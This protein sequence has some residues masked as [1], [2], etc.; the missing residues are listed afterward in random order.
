MP[1]SALSMS[2]FQLMSI[3]KVGVQANAGVAHVAAIT[4]VN[5]A[6]IIFFFI[7]LCPRLSR[8]FLLVLPVPARARC[9]PVR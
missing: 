3:F 6:Q 7:R 2:F 9:S 5:I 8:Q 1:D 4:P